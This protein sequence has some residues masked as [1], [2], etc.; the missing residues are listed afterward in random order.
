MLEHATL[1]CKHVC[2]QLQLTPP[3]LLQSVLERT[4]Q[5]PVRF[6]PAL[7]EARSIAKR[8]WAK[9]ATRLRSDELDEAVKEVEGLRDVWVGS[10]INAWKAP[11]AEKAAAKKLVGAKEAAKGKAPTARA[12]R[13]VLQ[14]PR[15]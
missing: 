11:S 1:A 12:F 4:M 6:L 7:P 13:N 10:I 15:E 9:D 14:S 8:T 3:S 2:I 5:E